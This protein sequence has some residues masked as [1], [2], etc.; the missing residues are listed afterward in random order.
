M[1][2]DKLLYDIFVHVAGSSVV[3]AQKPTPASDPIAI[4]ITRDSD[5]LFHNLAVSQKA[6]YQPTF[7]HRRWLEQRKGRAV[8]GKESI[9]HKETNL[10]PLRGPEALIIE[11]VKRSRV[12]ESDLDAFYNNVTLKKHQWDAKRAR[13]QEFKLVGKRLLELVGGTPGAKRDSKNKVIIG[14]GL[15]EFSSSPRLPSLHTAFLK[16][17]VQLTRSLDYIIVGVN[18]YY[19]SKRCPVCHEFVGQVDIRQLYR[20]T[21][22]AKIHRDVMAA[23]NMCNIIQGHLLDHKRPHYLRPYDKNGIYIWEL[24]ENISLSRLCGHIW[25]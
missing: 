22:G 3:V 6:V 4:V 9:A 12:V 17:F 16:Y 18:K 14:V 1:S 7:K 2:F 24:E 15:G 25:P 23:H 5:A 21:C 13:D 19:T 11:Y 8:E 10:P 20:P